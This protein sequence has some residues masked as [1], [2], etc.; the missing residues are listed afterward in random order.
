MRPIFITGDAAGYHP[1]SIT[2]LANR[3]EQAEAFAGGMGSAA[4]TLVGLTGGLITD[5]QVSR[6]YPTPFVY[7]DFVDGG[8]STDVAISGTVATP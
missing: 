1:T 6:T 3:I 8:G 2:V 7:D 4:I 5:N